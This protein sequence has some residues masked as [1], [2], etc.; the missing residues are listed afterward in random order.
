MCRVRSHCVQLQNCCC[1]C[2]CCCCWLLLVV[3]GCCWLLLVVVGC[4]W[5][6]LVV[7]GCCWLLLVV[8]VCCC[9]LLFVVVCCCLLLLL[10]LPPRLRRSHSFVELTNRLWAPTFSFLEVLNRPS[11]STLTVGPPCAPC[12]PA[13][14]LTK[15]LDCR[16]PIPGPCPLSKTSQ[17]RGGGRVSTNKWARRRPPSVFGLV[18]SPALFRFVGFA[19][20]LGA[21][22][23]C[24]S[25]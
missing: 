8:V 13:T 15:R 25:E 9:L 12:A 7:V 24:H 23:S 17:H 4:C 16:V 6:L 2:C 22:G 11:L 21:S 10:L 5:L 18:V 3:V 14:N 1:C 19:G 20:F